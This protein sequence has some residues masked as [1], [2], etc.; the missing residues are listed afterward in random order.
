M[1]TTPPLIL[2]LLTLFLLI[3]P[4]ILAAPLPLLQA[5]PGE[6]VQLGTCE[7]SSCL[8]GLVWFDGLLIMFCKL[9]RDRPSDAWVW[10]LAAS[11]F[12][13]L[14]ILVVVGR[15]RRKMVAVLPERR[16]PVFWTWTCDRTWTCNRV[17]G[18][19]LRGVFFFECEGLRVG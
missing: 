1:N 11:L 18:R 17:R 8:R 19:G 4:Q 6:D 9:V 15:R 14:V 7:F 2:T 5:V 3:T 13:L 12:L 16:V 10:L